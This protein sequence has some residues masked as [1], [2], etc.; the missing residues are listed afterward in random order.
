MEIIGNRLQLGT[1][2]LSL[3]EKHAVPH[4]SLPI[5]TNINLYVYAIVNIVILQTCYLWR[6][7]TIK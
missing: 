4:T 6:T 5:K 2:L 7:L 3:T 1:Q